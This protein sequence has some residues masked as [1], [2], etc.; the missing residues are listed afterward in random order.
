MVKLIVEI[1]ELPLDDLD[2][3]MANLIQENKVKKLLKLH[4]SV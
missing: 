3:F 1:L 4:F 2:Q